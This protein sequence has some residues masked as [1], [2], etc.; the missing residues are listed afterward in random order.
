MDPRQ[1][2]GGSSWI[3]AGSPDLEQERK[4]RRDKKSMQHMMLMELAGGFEM[5]FLGALSGTL[6]PGAEEP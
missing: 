5:L 6:E 1:V 3:A 2:A 4:L